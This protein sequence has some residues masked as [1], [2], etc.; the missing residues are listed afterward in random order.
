MAQ[1]S[2]PGVYIQERSSGVRTITGVATSIAA[3]VDNFARGPLDEAVQCLGYADYEREFGGLHTDSAAS[4]GMRQF[5]QNGGGECWV[6]RV[7]D[8]AATSEVIVDDT[9][10]AGGTVMFR[11]RAGRQIRG[12]I[13]LN[14]GAWGNALMLEVDYDC[15]DP[16]TQFNLAVSEVLVADGRRTVLRSETFRNLSMDPALPN[17][18]L[19]V[20]NAGSRL[21][22]LNDSAEGDRISGL[23]VTLLGET[24]VMPQQNAPAGY[25]TRGSGHM[26]EIEKL[27][28]RSADALGAVTLPPGIPADEVA[29]VQE[30][31][32]QYFV[33]GNARSTEVDAQVPV[34]S[35][36]RTVLYTL[37]FGAGN[38]VSVEC[39]GE[40]G[41][42]AG[43]VDLQ[44]ID[45]RRVKGFPAVGTAAQLRAWWAARYPQGGQLPAGSS[46]DAE[47]LITEMN[48]LLTAGI[49]GRDWFLRNHGI[50]VM[51]AAGTTARLRAAHRVPATRAGGASQYGVTFTEANG[52][53]TVL[54][55]AS[56]YLN[57][58]RLFRGGS[59]ATALPEVTIGLLYELGHSTEHRD[60]IEAAFSAWLRANPQ[61][62][63]IWYAASAGSEMFPEVW[64]LYHTDPHFLCG[65]APQLY[66]WLDALA[67]TGSPPATCPP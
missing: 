21:V 39:I 25:A 5:F 29:P 3:F 16:A 63:P 65:H 35:G 59:A 33:A 57:N 6:V 24:E 64:A 10:G 41:S 40:R 30:A 17:H 14:P 62:A 19:A 49:A 20:V 7:A 44:R 31:V 28:T 54:F 46:V 43:M 38:A 52:D 8:G 55:L 9:A 1:L 4:Y 67:S 26:F 50:D 15:S 11:A 58:T 48:A 51:D 23:T 18:A 60:G 47:A 56:L 34:G 12:E 66:A 42:D 13:A 32:R 27:Q 22:Q 53:T 61:A 2:C 37:T 45:V 36:S